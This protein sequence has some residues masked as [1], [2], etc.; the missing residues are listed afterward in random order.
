M[1]SFFTSD[2][3]FV[4]DVKL[5]FFILRNILQNKL[6]YTLTFLRLREIN[7]QFCSL[8][9]NKQVSSPHCPGYKVNSSV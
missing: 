8:V 3:E 1:F 6:R 2:I 9:Q 7:L 5:W 4:H